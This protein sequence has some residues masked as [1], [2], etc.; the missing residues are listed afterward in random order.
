MTLESAIRGA[1]SVTAAASAACL[2]GVMDAK[3]LNRAEIPVSNDT[4]WMCAEPMH[5]LLFGRRN[6]V[7]QSGLRILPRIFTSWQI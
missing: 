6:D 5:F 1:L 7:Q 3:S 4:L 2:P